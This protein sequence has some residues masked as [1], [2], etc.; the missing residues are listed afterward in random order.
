MRM[1]EQIAELRQC[2][3]D[4]NS[5]KTDKVSILQDAVSFIKS[6]KRNIISLEYRLQAAESECSRLLAILTEWQSTTPRHQPHHNPHPLPVH[7]HL[8]QV[9]TLAPAVVSTTPHPPKPHAHLL[10]SNSSLPS[11]AFNFGS[12]A[13]QPS[14]RETPPAPTATRSSNPTTQVIHSP[15][16]LHGTSWNTFS[17]SAQP[18]SH[19]ATGATAH[20]SPHF[21]HGVHRT[22]SQPSIMA[23]PQL[24]GTHRQ[25]QRQ[26]F[27]AV[28]TALPYE[29]LRN[30][31][32]PS[33]APQ[34]SEHHSQQPHQSNLEPTQSPHPHPPSSPS[35][36]LQDTQN[37]VLTHPADQAS[38]STPNARHPPQ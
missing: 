1:A 33:G 3:S 12:I 18:F 25:S 23:L 15:I 27:L 30:S 10:P 6:A 38:M 14:P 20:P 37:T 32:P 8:Q 29:S 35:R 26:S 4:P 9:P 11:P 2:V 19:A 7:P 17:S 34:S 22:H 16:A 13:P 5:G 31:L 21:S 24:P 36:P 28:H